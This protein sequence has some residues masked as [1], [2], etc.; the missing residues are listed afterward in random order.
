MTTEDQAINQE[1]IKNPN[2]AEYTLESPITFGG[3]TIEKIRISKPGVVALSGVALQDIMRSDVNSLCAVIP[4]CTYPQIPAQAMPL[5]DPT[6]L[7]QI[8][9]YIIYFL[10]PKSQRPN[11]QL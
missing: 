8:G 6:D 1:A 9:G 3:Q 10:M 7:L 11:I 4:K 5:L 2:E